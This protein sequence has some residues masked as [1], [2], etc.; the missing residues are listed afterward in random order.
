[1]LMTMNCQNLSNLTSFFLH[2]PLYSLVLL[3]NILLWMNRNKL[4]LNSEKTEA[5]SSGSKHNLSKVLADFMSINNDSIVFAPYLKYLAVTLGSSLQRHISDVCHSTSLVFC[6]QH[7]L[8]GICHLSCFLFGLC[9]SS[10]VIMFMIIL[11][12]IVY[13][14]CIN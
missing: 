6:L 3:S 12:C 7:T 10:L 1:M 14:C 2:N 13:A 4:K 8:H 9:F 11:R 5:T